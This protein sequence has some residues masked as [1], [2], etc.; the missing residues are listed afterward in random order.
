MDNIKDLKLFAS[1]MGVNSNTFDEYQ[2]YNFRNSYIEPTVIEERSNMGSM[3][4]ISV[5]SRL[6]MDRI[7]C[8]KKS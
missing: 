6:L 1:D 3:T 7:A 8:E 5:Y 4:A 2:K